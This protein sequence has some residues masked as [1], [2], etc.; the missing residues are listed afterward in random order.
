MDPVLSRLIVWVLNEYLFEQVG[1]ERII[2]VREGHTDFEGTG[3]TCRW[4]FNIWEWMRSYSD[5]NAGLREANL[6]GLS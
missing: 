1:F 6:Q 2:I 5:W 4:E 3:M